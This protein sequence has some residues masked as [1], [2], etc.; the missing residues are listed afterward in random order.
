MLDGR[1]LGLVLG[2]LETSPGHSVEWKH[3]VLMCLSSPTLEIVVVATL[4][5]LV[6]WK[7]QDFTISSACY[8]T[9]HPVL[10]TLHMCVCVLNS[11]KVYGRRWL[12]ASRVENHKL[13]ER[14]TKAATTTETLRRVSEQQDAAS[15][16][17]SCFSH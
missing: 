13:P 1:R 5:L 4:Y 14:D 12:R 11:C 10:S 17:G 8:S 7:S 15:W 2:I 6:R 16:R 3:M 9:H